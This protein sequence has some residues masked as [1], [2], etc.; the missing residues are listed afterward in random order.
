MLLHVM[1]LA[2]PDRR[3]W[4]SASRYQLGLLSGI[5]YTITKCQSDNSTTL[6]ES[7]LIMNLFRHVNSYLI[8]VHKRYNNKTK[9]ETLP[10]SCSE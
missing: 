2:V 9:S 6:L 4:G 8:S 7:V 5:H 10:C 1:F 3:S